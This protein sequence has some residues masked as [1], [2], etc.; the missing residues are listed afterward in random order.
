VPA[1]VGEQASVPHPAAVHGGWQGVGT[2]RAWPLLAPA[3]PLEQ[4]C[5]GPVRGGPCP[6]VQGGGSCTFTGPTI[7]G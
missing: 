4:W 5:Q 6:Q 2:T 1:P 3:A 7:E